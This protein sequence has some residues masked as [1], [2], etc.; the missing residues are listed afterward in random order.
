[1]RAFVAIEIASSEVMDGL[2]AFQ[3]E[4]EGT[5]ADLKLVERANLHFTVKFLGEVTEARAMEVDRRLRAMKLAGAT[6]TVGG[7][8]AFPSPN[9]P[10][11]VWTGVASEDSPKVAAIAEPVIQALRGIGEEDERPFQAHLTLARVRSGANRQIL[12]RF[13]R[14]SAARFF[15]TTMLSEFKLKSS[16]LTPKGPIYNDVGVYRL[17]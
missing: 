6:V 4:L 17:G 7:I 12:E 5:R 11:V 13:L 2:V 16:V 9:R 10:R 15:G 8:G 3:K 14:S 1:L